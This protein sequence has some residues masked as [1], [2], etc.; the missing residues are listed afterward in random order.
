MARKASAACSSG[1]ISWRKRQTS[2]PPGRRRRQQRPGLLQLV[3]RRRAELE[4]ALRDQAKS[5]EKQVRI[6][7][8][9]RLLKKNQSVHDGKIRIGKSG[10]PG[11]QLPVKKRLRR[12]HFLQQL[13]GNPVDRAGMLE[14]DSHPSRSALC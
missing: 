10:P 12:G 6:G 13:A 11:F 3:L 7:E 1:N 2:L 9:L 4:A 14:I 5:A 8:V